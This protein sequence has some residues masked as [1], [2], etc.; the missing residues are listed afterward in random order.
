MISIIISEGYITWD[1]VYI[2][3]K[4]YLFTHV[5]LNKNTE[6]FWYTLAILTL[7]IILGHFYWLVYGFIYPP[8]N[9]FLVW[10]YSTEF[11][12][13]CYMVLYTFR[14]NYHCYI[15][16]LQ[17]IGEIPYNVCCVLSFVLGWLILDW[18]TPCHSAV[19]FYNFIWWGP[20][21]R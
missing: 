7:Y 15:G 1:G 17:S 9:Y 8:F 3:K 19:F 21:I 5:G 13:F 12:F 18:L 20:S 4:E 10:S 11:L 6:L 16:T 14:Y 2:I